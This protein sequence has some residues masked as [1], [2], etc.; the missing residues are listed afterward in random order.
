MATYLVTGTNRG[1]GLEFVKQLLARGETVLA[2]CRDIDKAEALTA[3]QQD[4]DKLELFELDVSDPESRNNFPKRLAGK[5]IDVFIN[6]AGVYGPR[7]ASFGNVEPQEW[8][9]VLLINSIA[10][11]LLTQLLID[12]FR[13]GRGKKLVYIS[14]KMGS[15]DDNQG[16]GQYIYRTS[17]AALN[18]A[19]K[20]LAVDLA[21]A[22]FSAAV[23]HPGWVQ[24]DMGGP[25]ALI[26][27]KTS[28]EG[29]LAVIDELD[30]EK[31]GQFLNYDGSTIAW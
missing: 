1:I 3:L 31:S 6:N 17:K 22:G 15:I 9:E 23:L 21:D 14:S 24:T 26:D 13:Q 12:N 8:A 2:T 5:A 30:M 10:P 27:T 11:V 18:A 4:N 7:G 20:S 28:V 16:G 29:M 25:N 19:V